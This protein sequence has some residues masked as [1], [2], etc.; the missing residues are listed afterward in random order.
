[1]VVVVEGYCFQQ[2]QSL[3]YSL[4]CWV[5]PS[6]GHYSLQV[7]LV[8]MLSVVESVKPSL[9][10]EKNVA[11]VAWVALDYLQLEPIKHAI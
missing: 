2:L 9:V 4:M 6:L 7:Y 8:L 5:H 11:A 1:M 10:L 3:A